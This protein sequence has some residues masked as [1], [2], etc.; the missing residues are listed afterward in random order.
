MIVAALAHVVI[1]LIAGAIALYLTV[2]T[3]HA[4]ASRLASGLAAV[5]LA[6]LA[7]AFWVT[8]LELIAGHIAAI[9]LAFA[10]IAA[11][12]ALCAYWFPAA[13]PYCVGL[14]FFSALFVLLLHNEPV[15]AP[16]RQR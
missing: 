6:V 16:R 2:R 3:A 14:A 7:A 12:A 13:R 8:G 1:S 9:V 5:S 11:S 15:A 10:L 4:F